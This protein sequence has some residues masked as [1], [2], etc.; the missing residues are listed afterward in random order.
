MAMGVGPTCGGLPRDHFEECGAEGVEVCSCVDLSVPAG[1]LGGHVR[2][3][4]DDGPGARQ[5]RVPRRCHSEVDELGLECAGVRRSATDENYVPRAWYV[6]M[7][8]ACAVRGS[9]GLG[10]VGRNEETPHDGQY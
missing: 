6:S 3:R 7:H 9:E 2:G 5:L 4:A 10:D 8:D 1:L